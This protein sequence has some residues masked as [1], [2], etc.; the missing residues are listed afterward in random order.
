MAIDTDGNRYLTGYFSGTVDFNPMVGEDSKTAAGGNDAFV[1]RYNADGSYA[2]TRTFGGTSNDSGNSITVSGS[3]LYVTGAFDSANAGLGGSGTLSSTGSTDAFILALNASDGALIWQQKFGGN[4]SDNARGIAVSDGKVVVAGYYNSSNAGVGGTGSLAQVGGW[5]GFVIA[6]NATDGSEAWKLGFG[7]AQYDTALA[8]DA[9]SGAA[10]VTGEFSVT[11]HIYGIGSGSMTSAGGANS[12][13]WALNIADGSTIWMKQFGGS[14]GNDVG[15]GIRVSGSNLFITGSF[16]SP[17]VGMGGS[18][19]LTK[20][21]NASAYILALNTADG[22][23]KWKQK[24]GGS[25]GWDKG[26]GICAAGSSVFVMGDLESSNAGVGALGSLGTSGGIDAFILALNAGDGSEI[27]KQKFGGTG[28]DNCS[29]I[30]TY[31]STV[32]VS[33]YFDSAAAGVGGT[34]QASAT[35]FNGFL[36]PLDASSGRGLQSIAFTPLADKLP[37]DPPFTLNCTVS[38]GLP[39]SFSIVSGPA[40]ISGNTVTI[41]G[42]GTVTVRAS[43]AGNAN[44]NAALDVDQSFNVLQGTQTITFSPLS[45]KTY[46]DAPFTVSATGGASG[47]PVTFSIASGPATATGPNGSTIGLTGAGLVTVR[48]SQAGN[49]NYSAAL[50][51]DRSF[52]VAQASQTITFGSLANKTYGDAP[53]TVSATGGASGNPVTFFVSGPATATGTNGSTITLIGAGLVIVRASQAGN[54]NYNAAPDVDQSFNVSQ[55]SQTITFGSL[56]NRTYGDA[57]F[58]VSATGGASGNPVTFAIAN[59]PAT[60]NG[61]EI[62][63]TGAGLLTVRASQAGNANYSAAPDVDQTFNVAQ[64]SQTITFGSLANKTYG[65]APFTVSATGGASGNPVT[66]AIANGPA[67]INGSEITL[68]GAGLLTVRASQAGNANY[69]AAPDVDR[70]FNVAQASQTITFGSLANKTYGDAPFTVSA[71]GGASG[72]PVT[73]AI[74]SGPATINGNEVTITGAGLVT[75]RASQLG[76]ANYS[77]AASVDQSFTV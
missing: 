66:F 15:R 50:D 25:G 31:G 26:F 65:D 70:S 74:A 47:N 52:N 63:L 59:G 16:E 4:G 44:Y 54:A 21:G 55:A 51:V 10:Y 45:S 62:T 41:T 75:V 34:G 58:T 36:L 76:N 23:E 69:S 19:S 48:A 56:A 72:N 9:A 38:S 61:S 46:G 68:T 24:F 53:F 60:I 8:V 57:P 43:Q 27:W 11:A 17:S 71:T 1:S 32:W 35:G 28:S 20:L 30:T 33:G 39:V 7:S 13:I 37:N 40:T 49:A 3:T 18:G 12:Y 73:F 5:D 6:L 29:R 64:A 2:W 42:G 14:T 22:T 77:A 67:T